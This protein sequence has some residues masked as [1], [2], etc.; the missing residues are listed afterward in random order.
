[1]IKLEVI[2][3]NNYFHV[4]SP[5]GTLYVPGFIGL[6]LHNLIE[7]GLDHLPGGK[8]YMNKA[9]KSVASSKRKSSDAIPPNS[10]ALL[11]DDTSL[12]PTK[13]CE[14]TLNSISSTSFTE[15]KKP[16]PKPVSISDAKSNS[17]KKKKRKRT[18]QKQK[19]TPSI[20]SK[21]TTS[22]PNSKP[23][24]ITITTKHSSE[25][26]SSITATDFDSEIVLLDNGVKPCY[27][28]IKAVCRN[29]NKSIGY[30]RARKCT[31]LTRA[32]VDDLNQKL[33]GH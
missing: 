2:N 23:D 28:P 10:S 9:S 8:L 30:R 20:V 29:L 26:Q 15:D 1:M 7:R 33:D 24:E 31:I 5:T 32:A 25:S 27:A 19:N 13:K 16:E 21:I 4:N 11:K 17:I 22:S 3:Q 6:K 12:S 14:D 18:K